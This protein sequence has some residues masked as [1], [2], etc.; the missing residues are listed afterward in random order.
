MA[1]ARPDLAASAGDNSLPDNWLLDSLG[2][3][4]SRVVGGVGSAL[5][6]LG[7]DLTGGGD[8][9]VDPDSGVARDTDLEDSANTLGSLVMEGGLAASRPPG[10]LGVFGGM[11]AAGAPTDALRTANMLDMKGASPSDIW[12]QTGWFRG[13]D[14]KWRFEIPDKGAS[15]DL[16]SLGSSGTAPLGSVLSHPALFSAYPDLAKTPVEVGGPGGNVRGVYNPGGPEAAENI[17]LSSIWPKANYSP[18]STLLHESQHAIQ[19]REGF[20]YG[21]SPT[22]PGMVEAGK[23]VLSTMQDRVAVLKGSSDPMD[24]DESSYLRAMINNYRGS[25]EKLAYR[26]LSG[27]VEARNVQSRFANPRLAPWLP[28][29]TEDTSRLF[30]L[31]SFLR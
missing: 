5:D 15:V 20:A 22:D 2:K 14:Q 6:Y 27:E 7:R 13:A 12:Q 21:G 30:Q 8:L 11:R 18:L 26:S 16:T 28:D 29:L 23:G 9:T 24:Q 25:P 19:S 17:S 31:L 10:S 3:D 1:S 4:A